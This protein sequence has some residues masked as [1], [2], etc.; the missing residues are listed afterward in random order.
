[1]ISLPLEAVDVTEEIL[2]SGFPTEDVLAAWE[3]GEE[4]E[5]PPIEDEEPDHDEDSNLPSLRFDLGQKVDCRVGP[6][7]VT[8]WTSGT[9]TELWYREES[10][11]EG[12]FAPYKVQLDDGRAIFAP[13][14]IDQV[15]RTRE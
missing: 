12:S 9:V 11:P 6:D 4:A 10:W 5:W 13:G 15:I 1:M 2:L 8:G 3:R 7:P 14:D